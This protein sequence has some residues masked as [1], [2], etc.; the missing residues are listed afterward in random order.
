MSTA[1]A[2]NPTSVAMSLLER[3]VPLSLLLDLVMG[4]HSQELYRAE[5]LAVPLPRSEARQ[6]GLLSLHGTRGIGG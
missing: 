1:S 5:L 3:G 2:P 4:P 6:A